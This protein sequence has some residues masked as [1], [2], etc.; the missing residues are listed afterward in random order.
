MSVL[1]WGRGCSLEAPGDLG[2]GGRWK[3]SAVGQLLSLLDGSVGLISG[4][5][6]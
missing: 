6:V 2:V 4:G 1:E 5:L 3:R